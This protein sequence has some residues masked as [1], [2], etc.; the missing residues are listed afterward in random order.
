MNPEVNEL[1]TTFRNILHVFTILEKKP[2]DYGIGIRLHLTEVQTVAA[3]GDHPGVNITQLSEIMGV[4]RGATS[5]I[6]QKL[7]KKD[8]VTRIKQRNNKEINL[9]LSSSGEQVCKEFMFNMK[10]IFT[11][12]NDLYDTASEY[13]RLLAKRLFDSIYLN[14]RAR[15]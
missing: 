14:L 13:D 5:Q 6:V 11:F 15:I 2:L 10:E 4:T 3:I 12:A 7:S 1:I 8:L 9:G